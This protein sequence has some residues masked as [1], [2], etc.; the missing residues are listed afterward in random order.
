M[1]RVAR[2][3]L[4]A[5]L[6]VPEG[7][8]DGRDVCRGAVSAPGL[9]S[10]AAHRVSARKP[11]I[12]DRVKRCISAFSVLK[13]FGP[14]SRLSQSRAR[15][16]AGLAFLVLAL[17]PPPLSARAPVARTAQQA[18]QSV[19]KIPNPAADLRSEAQAALDKKDYRTA[20]D[21]LTRYLAAAP[22][23]P[24]GHF[25]LGYADTALQRWADAEAEYRKAVALDPKM[26]PAQLNLGLVLL[27]GD[28][29][30]AIGPL[31]QA[32]ILMP[33]SA[34][35]H[36]LL[37]NA[38]ERAGK[39]AE[40]VEELRAA[41]KLDANN[42]ATHLELARL[43]LTL[44]QPADGE[45]EFRRALA[46]EPNSP[47]AREGLAD[48]LLA[49]NHVDQ[50]VQQLEAY[51]LVRPADDA[52][53][54]RLAGLL[55][56]AGRLDDALAQLAKISETG[57]NGTAADRLR[58]EILVAQKK[59]VEATAPLERAAAAA[60]ADPRLHAD[61]GRALLRQRKYAA[62][63][64]ELEQ[65]VQLDPNQSQAWGDL[66][67]ALDLSGQ[68]AATL[69]AIDRLEQFE[70]LPPI[71]WFVRATCNDH[72]GRWAAAIAAYRK[73]LEVDAGKLGTEE[74][75]AKHRLPVLE[76]L[77]RH[78]KKQKKKKAK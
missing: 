43:L 64:G 46:L 18:H 17:F 30:A 15:L 22:S 57:P 13:P 34:Q 4:P 66:A 61:L 69:D 29:A 10:G 35:P 50:G 65:A 27:R 51:L 70:P 48:S 32:A 40:A 24:Y 16:A 11:G 36:L 25:Q 68:W 42:F 19:T 37:A 53:R 59:Y 8:P 62:A 33:A 9:P 45:S 54:L 44:H 14:R 60:A 63:A 6:A 47:D 23:D 52:A 41:A 21:L 55:A 38:L 78:Q 77:L 73:F 26:A 49:E 12:R 75:Q 7:R 72:L 58:G 71:S 3:F 31:Q 56:N 28:P 2:A 20:A 5:R 76:D 74:Y 39:L 67:I 1:P